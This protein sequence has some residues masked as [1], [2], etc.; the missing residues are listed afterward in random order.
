MLVWYMRSLVVLLLLVPTVSAQQ[1]S[2]A[3]STTSSQMDR[4]LLDVTVDRLHELYRQHRYTVVQVVQWHLDRISK[5]D[6]IYRAVQTV[7]AKTALQEAAREDA[8]ARQPGFRPEP[9]WG[10]PIVTKANTSIN[11]LVTTDGWEGYMR[12]GHEL[13]A[14]R[15]ATIVA[16]L[17]AAGGDLPRH[18]KHARLCCERHQPLQRLWPY[19]QRLRCAILAGRLVRRHG[20]GCNLKFRRAGEWHGYREFHSD[21]CSHK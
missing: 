17:R 2:R 6:G 19:G 11:G 8:E 1:S 5:Y 4:D 20:H 3:A 21:A 18:Y 13:V 12:P 14:P 9:L 15:D 10:V 7:T 16:K